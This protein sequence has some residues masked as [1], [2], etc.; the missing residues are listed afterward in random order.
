[1]AE[2][3]S[4]AAA[5]PP[6]PSSQNREPGWRLI[7][8]NPTAAAR[9]HG[10]LPLLIVALCGVDLMA[11]LLGDVVPGVVDSLPGLRVHRRMHA[12][13]VRKQQSRELTGSVLPVEERP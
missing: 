3:G 2:P 13:A 9:G 6:S 11:D 5:A 7:R 1:M 12:T 8:S 4:D 10:E